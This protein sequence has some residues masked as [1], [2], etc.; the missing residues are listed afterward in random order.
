MTTLNQTQFAKT[1]GKSKGYISMLKASGRLVMTEDGKL[2]DV[3]ASIKL[4]ADTADQNRDDVAARHEAE[5]LARKNKKA[6]EV[7][8]EDLQKVKFSEGRAKEQH[9]KALQAELDYKKTIGE[10]VSKQE[11][12]MAVTDMVMTFRQSIENLPHRISADLVGKDVDVIR[13]LLRQEITSALNELQ[14]NCKK[15]LAGE[16]EA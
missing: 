8:A 6:I 11:M 16:V 14:S 15:K 13:G 5:R 9:F 10:L 7:P 2:V 12:Q 3:E 4:I 1:I